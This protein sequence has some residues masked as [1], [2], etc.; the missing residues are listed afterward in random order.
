M[1]VYETRVERIVD[2]STLALLNNILARL[3][4]SQLFG[5]STSAGV[6]Q[7]Q[8]A[9][10]FINYIMSFLTLFLPSK[11]FYINKKN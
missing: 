2:K 7:D 4:V 10:K 1:T 11:K 8:L 9:P 5:D 6:Q 3:K